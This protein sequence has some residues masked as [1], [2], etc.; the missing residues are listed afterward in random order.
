MMP[1]FSPEQQKPTSQR[2]AGWSSAQNWNLAR[3]FASKKRCCRRTGSARHQAG[4]TAHRRASLSSSSALDA[5]RRP[6]AP[7][8]VK[9]SAQDSSERV[10]SPA[11]VEERQRPSPPA[12]DNGRVDLSSSMSTGQDCGWPFLLVRVVCKQGYARASTCRCQPM[13]LTRTCT[14]RRRCCRRWL[15]RPAERLRGASQD[16]GTGAAAADA[17][18]SLRLPLWSVERG[19]SRV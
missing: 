13:A 15:H 6:T 11:L 4:R 18:A 7:D 10:H 12:G 3:L 2:R 8:H 17:E 14:S 5:A 19:A 1:S 9:M 16:G